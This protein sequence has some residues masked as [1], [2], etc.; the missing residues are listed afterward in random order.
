MKSILNYFI[1]DIT[2][3]FESQGWH[4]GL[5]L[6]VKDLTPD[7]AKYKPAV[8]R[9]CIWEILMHINTWRSYMISD[10]SENIQSPDIDKESWRPLP[11]PSDLTAWKLELKKT[12]KIQEELINVLKKLEKKLYSDDES[13]QFL[14]QLPFHDSYHTGQ[15]GFIRVMQG[16]QPLE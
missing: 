3:H 1:K 7:Q 11:N 4:A 14:R 15:I 12:L 5:Y 8:D 10:M 9:H 13:F 6:M 16:L 2:A